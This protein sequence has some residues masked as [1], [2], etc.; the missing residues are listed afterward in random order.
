MSRLSR[1]LLSFA[2]SLLLLS[3]ASGVA[4]ADQRETLHAALE[5]F[6]QAVN[7]AALDPAG[8]KP[9]Y[10]EALA[11]FQSL[12][13]AGVN[14]AALCF[15][16]GNTYYRLNDLGRAVLEY[17]RAERIAPRDQRVRRNLS[18]VRERVVPSIAPPQ[19]GQLGGALLL[20]LERL[21]LW[22]RV[23][24]TLLLGFAAWGW[25]SWPMLRRAAPRVSFAPLLL[26][27]A[28]LALGAHAAWE[29]RSDARTPEAVVVERATLRLGRGEGYEPALS[30]ALGPGVELRI[31]EERAGWAEVELRDGK[32]G[33][34]VLTAIERV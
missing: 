13:S 22:E 20:G 9:L 12:R 10:A 33:W 28:A 15:N 29:L 18:Y 14:S 25:M 21:S 23:T 30:D 34:I 6:D 7:R 8:A 24:I 2:L 4:R 27:V 3:V 31:I 32:R 19:S 17:R 1:P 5:A 26:A 11:R 16:L